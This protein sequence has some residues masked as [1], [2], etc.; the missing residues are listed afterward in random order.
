LEF[1]FDPQMRQLVQPI[2]QAQESRYR[3]TGTFTTAAT[4]L[5]NK[6]PYVINSTIIGKGEA[7]ATLTDDEKTAPDA[8]TVSTAAAFAFHALFPENDY[9]RKLLEA[10]TDLYNPQQGYYEGFSEKTGKP[11]T[12]LSS[13]TNSLILQSLL[14]RATNQQPLIRPET[15]MN[16][17]WW[18]AVAGGD[19]G[20]GLPRSVTQTARLDVSGTY[21]VSGTDRDREIAAGGNTENVK[22]SLPLSN[23][24]FPIPNSQFPIPYPQ[25][26]A[27]QH[28]ALGNI[29]IATGIPKRVLSILWITTLGQ[30]CGIR[31]VPCWA[32][33]QHGS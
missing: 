10:T 28:N 21:W 3:R 8:R 19:L 13:S 27:S 31:G 33:M 24:Q 29:S 26:I 6:P 5:S 1:G 4:T 15:A 17:L 22:P 16:S 25:P 11:E 2:L 20:R 30:R 23:S 14:Y 7:W 18:Q 9:S 32:F 12:A